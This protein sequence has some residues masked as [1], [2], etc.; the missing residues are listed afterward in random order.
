[1]RRMV[2]KIGGGGFESRVMHTCDHG[3][4]S[5]IPASISLEIRAISASVL[6][7]IR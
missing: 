7:L 3:I 6:Q 4:L 1:M 5:I 2:L